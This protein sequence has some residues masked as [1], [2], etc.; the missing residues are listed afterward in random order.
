MKINYILIIILIL[1]I[2]IRSVWALGVTR[3]I[4]QDIELMRGESA[5]FSFEIQAVTS[6]EKILCDY[7]ISGME[8]LDIKFDSEKIIVEPGSIKKVYGTVSV[9]E[10]APLGM[11]SGELTVSCGVV[12]GEGISG[13]QVRTTIGGSPFN[14]NVVKTRSKEIREIRPPEKGIPIE[15][16]FLII[17]IVI[18]IGVY[19]WHTKI[20]KRKTKK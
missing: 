5:D 7:S 11:Y 3:P 8:P 20:P 6:T 12:Q 15:I 18:I 14:V 1:L 16:I 13:S 19:Y 17:L 9:P 10:N 4:P 2:S